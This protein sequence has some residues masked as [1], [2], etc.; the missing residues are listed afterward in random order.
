MKAFGTRAAIV[1]ALM[2]LAASAVAQNK[3]GDINADSGNRL[4]LVQRDRLDPAGQKTFDQLNSPNGGSLFDYPF[5]SGAS[6]IVNGAAPDHSA[7]SF[8]RVASL[9][10]AVE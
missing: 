5:G 10:I 2:T 4:P 3:P 8:I 6:E 9:Q 1:V 7:P